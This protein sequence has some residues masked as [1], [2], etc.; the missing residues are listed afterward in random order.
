MSTFLPKLFEI[1]LR[2]LTNQN[3]WGAFAPPA[4]TPLNGREGY[5]NVK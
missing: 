1:L 5:A 4:T 2:F 3:F